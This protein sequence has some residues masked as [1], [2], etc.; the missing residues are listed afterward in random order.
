MTSDKDQT[1][2]AVTGVILLVVGYLLS[3]PGL[4]GLY[5]IPYGT[6]CRPIGAAMGLF[7]F[8]I[9][10]PVAVIPFA[11]PVYRA[12]GR[13]RWLAIVVATLSLFVFPAYFCLIKWIIAAH[14]L[15]LEP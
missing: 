6:A 7:L 3:M 14:N 12:G 13:M 2:A 11:V 1:R 4:L 5:G 9:G 8:G 10:T 15:T